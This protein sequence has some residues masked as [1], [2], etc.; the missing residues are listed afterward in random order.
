MSGGIEIPVWVAVVGGVAAAVGLLDRVVAPSWRWY[1]RRRLLRAVD[2]LNKRLSL[3]IQPFALMKRSV[4]INRLSHDPQVMQAVEAHVAETG[5]PHDIA[6]RQVERYAREICPSFSAM[7]YFGFGARISR[8]IGTLLYRV[9]LGAFDR[10]ALA[11][12]DPDATIIF[13]MNHRSNVDYLLVTYLASQSSALSYAVGEWARVWPLSR[14]I[15]SMGAYFVRRR[16]RDALYRSVLR[17]YVQMATEGGVTQAMFPEG[18]LSR[19]GSLGDPK[20][21]IISYI[22][23]DFDPEDGNDVLFVPVGLN[24]DRVLE[25]RLLTRAADMANESETPGAK[26]RFKISI[27]TGATF[28]FGYL[29]GRLTGRAHKFGYA[30]VSFGAPLSLRTF[31]R[32]ADA[33]E[34]IAPRLGDEI[35]RRIGAVVPVLPASLVA[36]VLQ[37]AGGPMSE[38][39]IAA[40]AEALA[41]EFVAGG[42]HLHLPRDD[43]TYGVEVGLRMLLLRRIARK[44]PEGIVVDPAEAGLLSFY[45]NAIAHLAPKR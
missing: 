14:L 16:S 13:V 33:G 30:C 36:T 8:W 38:A 24:Y 37:S 6:V 27:W 19:D 9:R 45:A 7:M 17:R 42:A 11:A 21:G 35:T 43:F 5:M 34:E 10:E 26:P 4:L 29:L 1:M 41:D 28:L 31:L 12:A 20:L 15:R 25:D 40:A 23:D 32:D 22:L 44:T 3:R 39:E 18:G 2:D